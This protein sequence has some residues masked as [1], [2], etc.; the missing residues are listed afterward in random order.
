MALFSEDLAANLLQPC[1]YFMV[2]NLPSVVGSSLG[3]LGE[4]WLEGWERDNWETKTSLQSRIQIGRHIDCESSDLVAWFAERIAHG[5]NER[6][7]VLFNRVA[8][9]AD[10]IGA[11]PSRK[12]EYR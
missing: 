12:I 3:A 10:E 1:S 5:F 9:N 6:V 4:G 8:S 2:L 11:L 7:E